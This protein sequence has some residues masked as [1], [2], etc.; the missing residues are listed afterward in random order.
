M[1]AY[2]NNKKSFPAVDISRQKVYADKSQK[3]M[4]LLVDTYI[5]SVVQN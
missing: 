5:D 1:R 2:E 3:Q 4:F